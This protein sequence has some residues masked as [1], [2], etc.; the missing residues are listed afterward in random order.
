MVPFRSA[1]D[2]NILGIP[3]ILIK[4]NYVKYVVYLFTFNAGLIYEKFVD[5]QE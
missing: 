5:Y 2:K 3:V 4:I 1:H